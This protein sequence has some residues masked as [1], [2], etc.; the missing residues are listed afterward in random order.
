MLTSHAI[1]MDAIVSHVVRLIASHNA[2]VKAMACDLV[3][4]AA[5]DNRPEVAL[6]AAN[7][8]NQDLSDPNPEIRCVAVAT[9]CSMP[10]L[11]DQHAIQ[12][13]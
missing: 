1:H 9:I 12:G 3:C 8:L 5:N 10:M 13:G 6:L 11:A 4:A 7:I 2:E